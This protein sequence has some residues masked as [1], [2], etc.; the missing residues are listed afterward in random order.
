MEN[1]RTE[2]ENINQDLRNIFRLRKVKKET[3]HTTIKDTRNFFILEK[4]NEE[5]K[6]E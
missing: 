6:T 4:E 2:E 5:I 1:P 3:I